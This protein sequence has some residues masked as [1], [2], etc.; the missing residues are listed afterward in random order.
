MLE[1]TAWFQ[2]LNLYSDEK[3]VSKFAFKGSTCTSATPRALTEF[4]APQM[5]VH[6]VREPQQQQRQNMFSAA[7]EYSAA[8]ASAM[9]L[10]SVADQHRF[11]SGVSRIVALA[12]ETAASSSAAGESTSNTRRAADYVASIPLT[13][14]DVDLPSTSTSAMVPRFGGFIPDP[15]D[16]DAEMFGMGPAEAAYVDPQQRRLLAWAAPTLS[17][18]A[19]S[20]NTTSISQSRSATS[21]HAAVGVYVG[22]ATTDYGKLAADVGQGATAVSATGSA[23]LSVAAGRVAFALDARGAAVAVDTACSSGLVALHLARRALLE[24]GWGDDHHV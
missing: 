24:P 17:T 3:P 18:Y 9:K 23:F 7:A 11:S 10:S 2:P 5:L 12:G 4:L 6:M 21:T 14:W 8:S 1:S 15:A 19:T 16:F 20:A 22:M 13:R